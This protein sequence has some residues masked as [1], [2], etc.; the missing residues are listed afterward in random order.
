MDLSGKTALVTNA[1]SGIGLTCAHHLAE[2]GAGI[3]VSDVDAEAVERA[4][5]ELEMHGGPVFGLMAD[6]GRARDVESL[7]GET[8]RVFGRLDIVVV[9]VP[10]TPPDTMLE[11]DDPGFDRALVSSVRAPFLVCQRAARLVDPARGAAFVLIGGD[12]A[13]FVGAVAAGATHQMT[14]AMARDLAASGIRVNAIAGGAAAPDAIA[15][16][17]A[18]LVDEDAAAVTGSVITLS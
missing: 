10:A 18:Y 7:L 6:V 2:L 12:A 5:S 16:T 14:A 8:M 13:P 1:A 9:T 15:R 11:I 4:E 3:V 17:V